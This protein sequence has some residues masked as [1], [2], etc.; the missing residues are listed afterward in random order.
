MD[1]SIPAEFRAISPAVTKGR[2][3]DAP[4]GPCIPYGGGV[5]AELLSSFF[6]GAGDARAELLSSFRW[7]DL[8]WASPDPFD[9]VAGGRELPRNGPPGAGF[10]R[11]RV[12][13]TA[14]T[15]LSGARGRPTASPSG[16]ASAELESSVRSLETLTGPL[17]PSSEARIGPEIGPLALGFLSAVALLD[18]S[19][20]GGVVVGTNTPDTAAR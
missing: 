20:G 7:L 9:G 15:A 18:G 12:V 19:G 2:G 3:T 11:L 4:R 17:G 13:R 14:V 1:S 8:R 10:Q 6:A 16:D 5:S